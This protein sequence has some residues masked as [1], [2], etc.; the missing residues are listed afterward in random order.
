MY[1]TKLYKFKTSTNGKYYFIGSVVSCL[2]QL[3][4]IPKKW[5]QFDNWLCVIYNLFSNV[6]LACPHQT[7]AFTLV[8]Y[9]CMIEFQIQKLF[10]SYRCTT[11]RSATEDYEKNLDKKMDNLYQWSVTFGKSWKECVKRRNHLLSWF[12]PFLIMF[13]K[14]VFCRPV[15]MSAFG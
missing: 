15:N 11:H 10:N 2:G 14:V 9:A 6:P 4:G 1:S 13:L 5:H 7:V 3:V 8:C 12:S